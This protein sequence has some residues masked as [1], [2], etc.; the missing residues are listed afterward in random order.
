MDAKSCTPQT[1]HYLQAN[2]RII[3]PLYGLLR[4]MDLIQPYRLEMAT[5]GILK[6]LN[7]ESSDHHNSLT[8]WW[9]KSVNDVIAKDLNGKKNGKYL[10]NLASDEYAAAI[11]LELLPK[12]TN[13]IKVAFFQEGKV[14]AV[15][16][17]RARGLMCRYIAE[18]QITDLDDVKKF[19]FD[20]YSFVK[21]RSDETTFVFDRPKAESGKKRKTR[22]DA[23]P[24]QEKRRGKR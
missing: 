2:L 12:D 17:K 6:D 1:L 22:E 18:N 9:S 13:Y 8:N 4:P 20:G 21:E 19:D 11:D 24:K 23:P 7:K 10:I 14:I 5:K 15:H 3:D 16:A